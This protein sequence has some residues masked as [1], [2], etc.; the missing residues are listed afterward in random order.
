M[1]AGA[2]T[3][4]WVGAVWKQAYWSMGVL[5]GLDTKGRF[6]TSFTPPPRVREQM[7]P[8]YA[9]PLR[10]L[11]KVRP[12]GEKGGNHSGISAKL[13]RVVFHRESYKHSHP[14]TTLS[15][16]PALY[17]SRSFSSTHCSHSLL[18]TPQGQEY[19][20]EEVRCIAVFLYVFFPVFHEV[21]Q[22]QQGVIANGDHV[23]W[24]PRFHGNQNNPGVQLFL[25][26]L[27]SKNHNTNNDENVSKPVS[28]IS[29]FWYGC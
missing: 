7:P 3:E 11:W 1:S 27:E 13:F 2:N 4:D 14:H 29:I 25:V 15:K 5:P 28:P 21:T 8:M 22:G 26:D 16:P 18:P 12:L 24:W 23:L 19:L 9:V 10:L 6:P 20:R 17:L